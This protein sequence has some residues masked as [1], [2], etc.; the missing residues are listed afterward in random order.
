[1]SSRSHID[2]SSPRPPPAAVNKILR[3]HSNVSPAHQ[4]HP[5]PFLFLIIPP[6][7]PKSSRVPAHLPPRSAHRPPRAPLPSPGRFMTPD[8]VEQ[9]GD[10]DDGEHC[11]GS[12][13]SGRSAAPAWS[14][15]RASIYNDHRLF[16]NMRT[17][18]NNASSLSQPTTATSYDR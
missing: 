7:L 16:F 13:N 10:K 8:C 15:L 4:L 2:F 12:G 5:F 6:I 3:C 14:L 9:A 11:V 18:T 17:L 1:M